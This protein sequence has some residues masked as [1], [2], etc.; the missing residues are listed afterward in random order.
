MRDEGRGRFEEVADGVGIAPT[1]AGAPLGF[2]DR[3]ITALPTIRSALRFSIA[4]LRGK[5]R[6]T[7]ATSRQS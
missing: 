2:Q 5:Q 6:R 4:D 7:A 1:R 3:G